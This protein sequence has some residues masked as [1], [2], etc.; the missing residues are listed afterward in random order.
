MTDRNR[1]RGGSYRRQAPGKPASLVAG[2]RTE[3]PATQEDSTAV[4]PTRGT[5]PRPRPT[6]QREAGA[7]G[8]G[9]N[10]TTSED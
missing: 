4:R 9:D 10:K 2:S 6:T 7:D 3:P 5:G 8:E 1:R